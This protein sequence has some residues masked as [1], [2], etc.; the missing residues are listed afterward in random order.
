MTVLVVG[1]GIAGLVH[2]IAARRAGH[3]VEVLEIRPDWAVAGWGL[4]LTGPA[5]RA[6]RAIDLADEC[7]AAG[8]P[9]HRHRH[10]DS[11]GELRATTE[12]PSVLGP[13]QPTEVGIGRPALHRIL[14]ERAAAG[15]ATLRTG[16]TV[17]EISAGAARL[18]DGTERTVDYLVGAD[19]VRSRTRE[20][21]GLPG[22]PWFTGQMVWRALVDRP[23]WADDIHTFAG[24]AG[25]TG[26]IPISPT[27]AYV[28][29]T[30][31]TDVPGEVPDE[32]LATRM[33][34][35]LAP[36]TGRFAAVRDAITE[37]GQVVRR[38]VQ[39][40]LVEGPWHAGR[41][42]LV[43]DAAHSPSP[44]MVS[45]AA[46]AIEDAVV[47]ADEIAR[48]DELADAFTAYQDRRRERV[49]AL[50]ETSLEIGRREREGRHHEVHQLI[51]RGH[52]AMAAPI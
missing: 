36:F 29:L 52:A 50:L 32:E 1:G 31:V 5:L 3:D 12:P 7:L 39:A 28:F 30:E 9:I 4:S 25:T 18:S 23:A 35:L 38:P 16:L 33:R 45:G 24:P 44:Q 41:G 2:A 27:Q 17:V 13:G 19:G 22:E 43:G 47:L 21:L 48:H 20:L 6:L 37:P 8:A 26:V 11:A 49:R 51:G 14:R 46:L 15:G 34:D 40:L 42:V 10:H